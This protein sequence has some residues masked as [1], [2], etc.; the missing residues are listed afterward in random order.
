MQIFFHCFVFPNFWLINTICQ[1]ILYFTIDSFL[2]CSNFLVGYLLSHTTELFSVFP[3]AE[4]LLLCLQ[5][6]PFF[7][8]YPMHTVHT[9]EDVRTVCP[10]LFV[11]Y[12]PSTERLI[13]LSSTATEYYSVFRSC[14]LPWANNGGTERDGSIELYEK[15][16][17]WSQI[18]VIDTE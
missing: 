10:R 7:F 12:F 11:S 15:P 8:I 13:P 14:C 9:S 1:I 5:W 6:H 4:L 2:I 3:S 18:C 17:A 16:I